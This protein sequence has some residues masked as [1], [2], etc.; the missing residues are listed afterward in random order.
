MLEAAEVAAH[1]AFCQRNTA[2]IPDPLLGLM[3]T[4]LYFSLVAQ[5]L[6]RDLLKDRAVDGTYGSACTSAP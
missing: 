3:V 4:A 6:S 5:M 2:A 1:L